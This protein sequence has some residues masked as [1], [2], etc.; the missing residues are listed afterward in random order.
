MIRDILKYTGIF[1]FLILLQALILNN[2]RLAGFMNPFVYVL[3]ILLLP[4]DTP[5][6]LLL[7][8]GFLLGLSVDIFSDTL[9]F[10]ASATV[11]AAFLRPR[12]IPLISGKEV[13]ESGSAPRMATLGF[14]WFVKYTAIIVL[15]HH[16][17]L[18]FAE[19]FTLSGFIS[20]LMRA[21]GSA[22]FTIIII[23]I[24]QFLVFRK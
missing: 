22:L 19:A 3:F 15:S 9:G 5:R 6:N 18:F 13:Y 23:L 12:I 2:V 24:S 11:L 17:F 20:T 16:L 14:N 8:I 4:F 21:L 1:V 10:H 7:V